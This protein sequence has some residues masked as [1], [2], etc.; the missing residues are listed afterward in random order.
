MDTNKTEYVLM[1]HV[2][3]VYNKIDLILSKVGVKVSLVG[4][5]E[6]QKVQIVV[7]L[8][9]CTFQAFNFGLVRE[10]HW[11]LDCMCHE[12]GLHGSLCFRYPGRALSL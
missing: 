12:K 7:Y 1:I 3:N 8:L 5:S 6:P 4:V 9:H 2:L 10:L 11:E